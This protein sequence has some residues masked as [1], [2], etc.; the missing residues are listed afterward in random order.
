M[1]CGQGPVQENRLII[2]T[3]LL[4]HLLSNL[5][6]IT[7]KLSKLCQVIFE[8]YLIETGFL[9]YAPGESEVLHIVD[10]NGHNIDAFIDR[11]D[12][13]RMRR[14]VNFHEFNG[15]ILYHMGYSNQVEIIN[16]EFS[17][18]STGI[19][20][21]ASRALT[22]ADENALYKKGNTDGLNGYI[23]FD[24]LRSWN[25]QFIIG[26]KN[27]D[28]ISICFV[29]KS[30][31]IQ[32]RLDSNLLIED[33]YYPLSLMDFLSGEGYSNDSFVSFIYPY[34]LDVDINRERLNK[35]KFFSSIVEDISN[36]SNPIIIE[37][38]Y[39]P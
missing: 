12:A 3:N 39:R 11:C 31:N 5:Q 13:V 14:A 32:R 26:E 1:R 6:K 28:S 10:D 4:K 37:Y 30:N 36:D 7:D 15:E 16:P 35:N 21:N 8:D 33:E 29:D 2:P 38:E 34:S 25:N 23:I 27:W 22:L 24:G 20:S 17:K 18:F 9:L 19:I